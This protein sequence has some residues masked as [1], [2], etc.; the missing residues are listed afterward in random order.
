MV[1][2]RSRRRDIR[3]SLAPK[4]RHVIRKVD[5][6]WCLKYMHLMM[7][8]I[9]GGRK[10]I[11]STLAPKMRRVIGKLNRHLWLKSIYFSTV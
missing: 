4:M 9:R 8:E 2:I 1:E 10:D 6:H 7:V 5:H 11:R 3:S